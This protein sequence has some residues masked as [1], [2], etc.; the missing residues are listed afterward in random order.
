MRTLT[1]LWS[2]GVAAALL[3]WLPQ[4]WLPLQRKKLDA[5]RSAH[6]C[7]YEC[8]KPRTLVGTYIQ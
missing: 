6:V 8:R 2:T 4:G 1:S 3:G 5:P 7:L